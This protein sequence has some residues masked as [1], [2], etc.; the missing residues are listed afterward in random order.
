MC[1]RGTSVVVLVKVPADLSAEGV[2][3]WKRAPIDACVAPIVAA[4]QA[5]G[6]DMRGSCCGH[7]GDGEIELQDGRVLIIRRPR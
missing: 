3:K 2:E 6:I 5:A 1:V 4:L 7:G